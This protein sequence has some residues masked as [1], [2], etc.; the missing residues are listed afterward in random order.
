MSY[1]SLYF[2]ILSFNKISNSFAIYQ[3]FGESEDHSI[4]IEITNST[5]SRARRELRLSYP[6]LLTS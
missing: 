6:P 3:E 2:S 4:E 5:N 1:F